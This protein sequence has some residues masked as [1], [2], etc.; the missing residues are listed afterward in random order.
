[1]QVL[2]T[3]DEDPI[4]AQLLRSVLAQLLS[5]HPEEVAPLERFE[6]SEELDAA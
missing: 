5:A 6:D 2:L 4:R 3:S 1:M